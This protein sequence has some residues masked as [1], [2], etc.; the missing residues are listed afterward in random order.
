MCQNIG[1]ESSRWPEGACFAEVLDRENALLS[2]VHDAVALRSW[3]IHLVAE[4]I[5]PRSPYASALREVGGSGSDVRSGF[6]ENWG[7]LIARALERAMSQQISDDRPDVQRRPGRRR[8]D[9]DRTAVLILAAVHGG[10]VLSRLS[11]DSHPIDA[12]LD[13]AL[14]PLL[15]D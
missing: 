9:A 13:L 6:L 15:N 5:D 4:V 3:R 1:V 12:A 11:L 8:I 14:A 7:R 2:A 10:A